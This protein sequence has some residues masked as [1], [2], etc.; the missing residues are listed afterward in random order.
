M[1]TKKILY[2]DMDDVLCNYTSAFQIIREQQPEVEFP[3]SVPGFF[4]NLK[5]MT[6]AVN[7]FLELAGRFDVHILSAPSVFNPLC[8]TEK[9]IWVENHLGFEFTHNLILATNKGL[10][11]G[12]YLIDDYVAGRGQENFEGELIHFGSDNYPD[13]L[14]IMK[15]FQQS[16]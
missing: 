4:E 15:Y 3:Q 11:K 7:S 8:Y 12:D 13:W 6:S 2:I 10:L 9:R 16:G 1:P 14:S 5:P